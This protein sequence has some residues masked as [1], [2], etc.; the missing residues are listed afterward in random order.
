MK[1]LLTLGAIAILSLVL[2]GCSGDTTTTSDG[3]SYD[4]FDY[5][6]DYDEIF[7]RRE[8][9]YLV[10]LYSPTCSICN[11]IKDTVLEF[12]DT[13]E[14]Y[15]MYFFNVDNGTTA[16]ETEFLNT[17]GLSSSLFG[18]PG[19]VLVKN[20]SFDKTALSL[21][22]FAG[23]TEIPNILRDIQNQSYPYFK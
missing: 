2:F 3:L 14:K 12:A 18:T 4:M 11:S 7:D 20:N 10:Y 6:E 16:L 19:L 1:K 17:I 8:G 23:G 22:Y 9:T 21:Y 5:I 15:N 13:Y